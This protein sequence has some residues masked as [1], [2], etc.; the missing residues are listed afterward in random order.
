MMKKVLFVILVVLL[1]T[2]C[3]YVNVDDFGPRKPSEQSNCTDTTEYQ[4]TQPSN[5]A[6]SQPDLTE[7]T[8]S[9]YRGENETPDW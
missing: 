5:T 6:T 7:S 2:L 1:L 4:E 9:E 8:E 3:L